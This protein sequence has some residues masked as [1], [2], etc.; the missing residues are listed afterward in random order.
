MRRL[1]FVAALVLAGAV[2]PAGL[3]AGPAAG[4]WKIEQRDWSADAER[5]TMRAHEQARCELDAADFRGRFPVVSCRARGEGAVA[6]TLT[7]VLSD[8]KRQQVRADSTTETGLF[9]TELPYVA[10][11]RQVPTNAVSV[12][13]GV[14]ASGKVMTT[15]PVFSLADAKYAAPKAF[16]LIASNRLPRC[17]AYGKDF[18]LAQGMVDLTDL[19]AERSVGRFD[20]RLS[21]MTD[22]S[23]G[24]F[25]AE[26]TVLEFAESVMVSEVR[27]TLPRTCVYFLADTTG[28]GTFDTKLA[29]ETDPINCASW[30]ALEDYVWYVCR[31]KKP[32][33]VRSLLVIGGANEVRVLGPKKGNPLPRA[34]RLALSPALAFGT[35]R[36]VRVTNVAKE[37]LRFGFCL[38]PWM[39]GSQSYFGDFH[40]RQKPMVPIADWKPLN[41]IFADFR[42][43]NANFILLFPPSTCVM[44][45]KKMQKRGQYPFPLM[46]PSKVWYVN[47]PHDVFSDFNR[48]CHERG[49]ENFT[50][51]REWLW[52]PEARQAKT[53]PQIT[54]AEEIAR[55][56]ADGVPVCRD[57]DTFGTG[58]KVRPEDETAYRKWSGRDRLPPQDLGEDSVDVRLGYLWNLKR[59]ADWMAEIHDRTKKINPKAL[60][61][62]GFAGCDGGNTRLRTSSVSGHD[63]WGF[64]GKCDVIGGDGNYYGVGPESHGPGF[65]SYTPCVQSATQVAYSQKRLAM[66][67]VNFNWGARWKDGKYFRPL[68]H[69]DYPFVAYTGGALAVFFNK[70][71]YLNFWRYNFMDEWGG[72]LVRESV[73]KGGLM[74]KTLSDW[75]GREATVPKDVLVLRSR[76]S[77]DWWAIRNYQKFDVPRHLRDTRRIDGYKSYEWTTCRLVENGV[78]FEVY[79]LHRPETW[80]SK[81]KDYRVIVLPFAYSVSDAAVRALKDAAASGT[82]LVVVGND[83]MGSTDDLGEPR[84]VHAFD[85]LSVTRI[86]LDPTRESNTPARAADF[87]TAL[88]AAFGAQGPSVTLER[89]PKEDVQVYALERSPTEKFLMVANWSEHETE[90]NVGLD[91][92]PGR[93]SLEV[94]DGTGVWSGT[95]G[96]KP[97][98]SASDLKSFTVKLRKDASFLFRMKGN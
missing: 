37:P 97:D 29:E 30:S 56:G 78:P 24:T 91:L 80:A 5:V 84:A 94:C 74:V 70:C 42:T 60:T 46:W 67:T 17:Y 21:R 31:L 51:P 77:E 43:L 85:G 40:Y 50:I 26:P 12:V 61:F 35:N 98:L 28:D 66:A 68:V 88:W 36:A 76:T 87:R 71:P 41:D 58:V 32:V 34:I 53:P 54:L 48:A 75:G 38:E 72:P 45:D 11:F 82:K 39:F 92:P 27:L 8:G 2:F 57:E 81:A 69:D 16:E 86:P 20:P 15:R 93:Y 79:L 96:G 47:Q 25:T 89:Q 7:A 4:S 55:G 33:L 10:R 64:E 19:A 13:L 59:T 9:E 6:L 44:P 90:A 52:S 62:G 3:S 83:L 95:I 1:R 14:S 63:A 65:E 73:R 49:I 23:F 18:A 22:R